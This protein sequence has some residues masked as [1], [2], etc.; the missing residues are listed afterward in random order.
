MT[1]EDLAQAL[2]DAPDGKLAEVI[3]GLAGSD[4]PEQQ[5]LRALLLERLASRGMMHPP[6]QLADTADAKA[7]AAVQRKIRDAAAQL[8]AADATVAD[9]EGAVT[10]TEEPERKASD[11]A[12]AAAHLLSQVRDDLVKA[13]DAGAEPARLLEL[14]RTVSDAEAVYEHERDRFAVAQQSGTAARE[15]LAGARDHQRQAREA[16]VA[17]E[18]GLDQPLRADLDP[19]DRAMTLLLTW[20]ARAW[21]GA[22]GD[23]PPLSDDEREIIRVLAGLWADELGAIPAGAAALVSS[24]RDAEIRER[25]RHTMI[26]LPGGQQA[27]V[28]A[29]MTGLG[30]GGPS[31]IATVAQAN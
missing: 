23:L 3:D 4:S 16:L 29:L 19:A 27:S 12:L 15:R 8:A 1:D 14:R 11:Q 31:P 28:A 24:Q 22:T 5:E 9:A 2:E 6:A 7:R 18:A 25:A 17:A 26:N 13:A 20:P 30:I 21:F 10:A